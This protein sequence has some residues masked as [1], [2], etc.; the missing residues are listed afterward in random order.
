MGRAEAHTASATGLRCG[1]R[2]ISMPSSPAPITRHSPPMPARTAPNTSTKAE[3]SHGAKNDTA[4]PVIVYRPN[5]TPS[6]P[7]PDI[8]SSS[9]RADDT[10]GPINR[11]NS[12]PK[13][14]NKRGPDTAIK[15]SP[16]AMMLASDPTITRLDPI[17]SSINPPSRAPTAATTLAATPNIST[18]AGEIPYALTPSTPPK[19]NTPVSPSRNN[20]LDSRK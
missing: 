16:T 3:N 9:V 2:T 7:S 4:R 15:V 6:L 14:Q 1:A 17:R 20:A 12:S 5:A 19:V 18:A 11:H 10:V 13:T 8:R